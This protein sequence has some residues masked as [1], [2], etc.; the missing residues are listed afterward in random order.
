MQRN[1]SGPTRSSSRRS[2]AATKARSAPPR[3]GRPRSPSRC[4]RSPSASGPGHRR[5][6]AAP[7][8]SGPHART[9]SRRTRR[10]MR[11]STPT[12][13]SGRRRAPTDLARL[14][15]RDADPRNAD[16][17]AVGGRRSGR[18]PARRPRSIGGAPDLHALRRPSAAVDQHPQHVH[19][20]RAPEPVAGAGA[21]Q[22]HVVPARCR[23]RRAGPVPGDPLGGSPA[24][25]RRPRLVRPARTAS[26]HA[27]DAPLAA[28]DLV[29]PGHPLARAD[30]VPTVRSKGSSRRRCR[31]RSRP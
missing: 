25:Q 1:A 5:P 17:R 9:S 16:Q 10:A 4:P 21:P 26:A 7:P 30:S 23:D 27:G 28:Q 13:T 29:Q 20:D 31:S 3:A 2:S 18:Q 19:A 14:A 22:P 15:R 8:R 11:P 6:A 12:S 24:R